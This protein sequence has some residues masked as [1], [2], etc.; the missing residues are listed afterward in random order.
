MSLFYHVLIIDTKTERHTEVMPFWT[1]IVVIV[2]Y[3]VSAD[4]ENPFQTRYMPVTP[5]TREVLN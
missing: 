3:A 1:I 5:N 4:T 2:L